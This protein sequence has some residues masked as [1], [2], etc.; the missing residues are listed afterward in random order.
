M[1]GNSLNQADMKCTTLLGIFCIFAALVS[2]SVG[3]SPRIPGRRNKEPEGRYT[4]NIKGYEVLAP[5]KLNQDGDF[6]SCSLP[7]LYEH[8][9][10]Q[11]TNRGDHISVFYYRRGGGGGVE[12]VVRGFE[13]INLAD[14]CM[15]T[16]LE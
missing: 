2:S 8:D 10:S 15:L 4:R 5:R 7:H 11:V 16:R 14:R 12:G 13:G 6:L 9:P 3:L 1:V